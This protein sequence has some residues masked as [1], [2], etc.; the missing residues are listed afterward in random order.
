MRYPEIMIEMSNRRYDVEGQK[1]AE[2]HK[3]YIHFI[4]DA[5][6]EA[7]Y[8]PYKYW[9]PEWNGPSELLLF[10]DNSVLFESL[11]STALG[12]LF[13]WGQV[14]CGPIFDNVDEND[15]IIL[16][17]RYIQKEAREKVIDKKCEHWD[18]GLGSKLCIKI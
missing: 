2:I 15:P 5:L 11:F 1:N 16:E 10:R 3:G 18:I 7:F 12:Q 4:F 9:V 17:Q 6:E 13:N 8:N 14:L